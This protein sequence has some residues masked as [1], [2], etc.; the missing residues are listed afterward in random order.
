MTKTYSVS[1]DQDSP[2]GA[3]SIIN[4][5]ELDSVIFNLSYIAIKDP[6]LLIDIL[7]K[8]K[9]AKKLTNKPFV[10]PD[11]PENLIALERFQRLFNI[12]LL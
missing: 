4:G 2:V 6:N 10:D 1:V 7:E 5:D 3:T 8:I 12:H 11:S 9:Q